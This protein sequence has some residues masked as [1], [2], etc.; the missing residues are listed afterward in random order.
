MIDY[1]NR[2]RQEVYFRP[3]EPADYHR[4]LFCLL[5]N[6]TKAPK[7]TYEQFMDF[8]NRIG[9]S[10][11][12]HINIVAV[13]RSNDQLVGFGTILIGKTLKRKVGYIE[14]IV[15][16]K[17]VRGQGYGRMIIEIL[18]DLGA[19]EHCQTITLYCAN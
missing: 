12:K 16:S 15:T 19:R 3:L 4:N 7:P 8:L 2:E 10:S 1:Y 13:Q 17:L 5:E 6:L 14:N 11:L 9:E 18:K